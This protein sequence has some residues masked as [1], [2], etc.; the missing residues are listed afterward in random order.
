MSSLISHNI[1]QT[2]NRSTLLG[3]YSPNIW[4]ELQIANEDIIF[5]FQLF[6]SGTVIATDNYA[7]RRET[8]FT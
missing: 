4:N 1:E 2:T 3:S 5:F 8:N 6:I 7:A